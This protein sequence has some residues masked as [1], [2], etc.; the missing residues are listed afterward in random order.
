MALPPTPL[1]L[2]PL[3]AKRSLQAHPD[4][5]ILHCQECGT[6]AD[7]DGRPVPTP[8]PQDVKVPERVHEILRKLRVDR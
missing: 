8:R 2:C 1:P 7:L 4:A 3:C 5:A 6:W